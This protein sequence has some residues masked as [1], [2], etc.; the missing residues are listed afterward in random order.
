M[1]LENGGDMGCKSIA[2]SVYM[3]SDVG[4]GV[5][6][7]IAIPPCG[8][9]DCGLGREYS[10]LRWRPKSSSDFLLDET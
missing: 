1:A 2:L 10:T 6:G 3:Y 9:I 8:V 5:N 4:P 7:V